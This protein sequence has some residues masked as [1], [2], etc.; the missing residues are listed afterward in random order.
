MDA[1]MN[2]MRW[3]ATLLDRQLPFAILDRRPWKEVL[4]EVEWEPPLSRINPQR[5]RPL[6]QG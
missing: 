4:A 5:Q 1:N 2:P 3:S 6:A